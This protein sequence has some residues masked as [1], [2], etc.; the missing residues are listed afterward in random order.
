MDAC[1]RR[2]TLLPSRACRAPGPRIAS[3]ALEAEGLLRAGP[4]G[5]L[6]DAWNDRHACANGGAR[7]CRKCTAHGRSDYCSAS[8]AKESTHGRSDASTYGASQY[9]IRDEWPKM[10]GDSS[11]WARLDHLNLCY[12]LPAF[13]KDSEPFTNFPSLAARKANLYVIAARLDDVAHTW[14]I[15]SEPPE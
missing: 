12:L 13:I 2:W 14:I 1:G 15:H 11:S 10:P 8:R 6:A 3:L 5:E 7:L 9:F 4:S